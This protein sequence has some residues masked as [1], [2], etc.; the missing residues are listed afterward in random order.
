MID[1]F[2]QW[3]QRLGEDVRVDLSGYGAL[4]DSALTQDAEIRMGEKGLPTTFVPARNLVFFTVAAAHA[5]RRG[6]TVLVGGMCQTDYS[7]YPD[8]R[9]STINAQAQALSLGLDETVTIETPLM[10]LSKA[11]TWALAA[12]LGGQALIDLIIEDSHTCY[13]GHREVRHDWGYGCA[14]CPACDLRQAGW[15]SWRQGA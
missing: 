13:R 7:G 9:Q 12:D 5:Y 4:S 6:I 3:S 11:E 10:H 1:A 2:P 14:D 15:A 8:C